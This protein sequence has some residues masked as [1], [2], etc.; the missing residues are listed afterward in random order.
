MG[1]VD[2]EVGPGA[3]SRALRD[4]GTLPHTS[5]VETRGCSGK[6]VP[7]PGIPDGGVAQPLILG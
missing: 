6:L 4:V 2:G 3:P 5:C 7:S 1:G